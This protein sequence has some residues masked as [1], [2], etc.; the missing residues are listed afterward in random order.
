MDY[1]FLKNE[2]DRQ[3]NL[4]EELTNKIK[5]YEEKLKPVN[6]SARGRKKDSFERNLERDYKIMHYYKNNYKIKMKDMC[7]NIREN[8][9]T[10][11]RTINY[12]K[13]KP[14]KL[15]ELLAKETKK[16]EEEEGYEEDEDWSD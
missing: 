10:V 6:K 11:N 15:N 5:E 7:E 9:H 14:E 4:I 3:Y 16:E 2:V 13:D 12:Y 1:E 8:Y